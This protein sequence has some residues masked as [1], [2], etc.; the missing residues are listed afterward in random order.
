MAK[1]KRKSNKSRAVTR[2]ISRRV[3]TLKRSPRRRRALSAGTVPFIGEISLHNPL[4]GGA[5]GGFLASMVKEEI[6]DTVFGNSTDPS[7]WQTKIKPYAKGIVLAAGGYFARRMKQPE[8]AAGIIGYAAGLTRDKLQTAGV[9][10]EGNS[11]SFISNPNLLSGG[12][13]LSEM[14]MLSARGRSRRR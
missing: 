13:M 8:V 2:T 1:R 5:V 3:G 12:N 10:G 4:I 11:A 7:S 9:I 14:Q 6:E